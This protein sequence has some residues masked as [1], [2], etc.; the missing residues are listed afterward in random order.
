MKKQVL[1]AL[2]FCSALG[3][4]QAQ[5]DVTKEYLVNPSFETLKAADGTTDVAVKTKLESGLYGWDVAKLGANNSNYQVESEESGSSTGFPADGSGKIKPTEG[6]Y[7][8]FNRQ[9]W[10]NK[11]SELKTTTSK[12]LPAG[13]YYAVIDYKAADYSN[14]NNANNNGTTIGIKVNDA[15]SNLLGENPAVRRAYSIANNGS[16]P[17][18]DAYM[19]NAAW[20]ELGT[21]FTVTEP[22]TVTI[23]LV[24]N[25]RNNGRSDIAWDN[26]RLYQI[27][28]VSENKPMDVSGLITTSNYYALGGWNIEGGNTFEVNTWSTEGEKDGSGMTTP[29]RRKRKQGC[30]RHYQPYSQPSDTGYLRSKRLDSCT[31]RS[32]RR[33]YPIRSHTLCQRR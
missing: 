8:Y 3:I 5:T 30:K 33:R 28:N 13:T 16:N 27:E 23:S 29:L 11:D 17:G 22:T 24:Q 9:G 21:M 1:S 10:G 18:N 12:E 15:A 14:N 7:Y 2:A 25:M 4:A 6:T 26:L 32:R 19:V 20:N 31:E